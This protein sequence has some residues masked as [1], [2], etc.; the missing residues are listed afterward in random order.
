MKALLLRAYGDLTVTEMEQPPIGPD[1]VL[2][3]VRAAGICGSDVHGYDGS[4]GRRIPPIVMG[5]E[6]A[7]VVERVGDHVTHLKPGER[8]TFDSTVY[9]GH[10]WFCRRGRINLC[11]QRQ[12]LGVSTGE[13]RRHGA[14]AQYIAIPQHIVYPI[15]DELSFEQAALIESVSIAVHAAN[16]TPIQLG[17][18]AV[19][20]GSGMIGLLMVQALRAAGCTQV[21]AVDLDDAKLAL[22]QQLGA[23]QCIDAGRM[24]VV[25]LVRELT[26]GRGADI[27]AEVVGTQPTFTTAVNALRKGGHL[28]LVGN[29]TPHVPL[30]LQQVVTREQTLIGSC[31][32]AR[33][34][35]ACIDMVSRGVIQVAP[36]ISATAPLEAG[37]DWFRRLH[38]REP[39]LMKVVLQP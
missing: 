27:A 7:G 33:E 26:D 11:D 4:S 13:Y 15:P 35:P 25:S 3:R 19:V 37:A 21:V 29:V 9:C 6:A 5:H 12:V 2:V 1:D 14:F 17:D 30:P 18:T 20:V 28:V 23:T 16:L 36:L 38:A 10:C 39:G 22:A 24:D 8:V 32:S 31:A 34:Y